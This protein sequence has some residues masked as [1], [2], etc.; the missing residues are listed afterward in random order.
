MKLINSNTVPFRDQV[1]T[2]EMTGEEL[3]RFWALSYHYETTHPT[4][5]RFHNQLT[6]MFPQ[7]NL[8]LK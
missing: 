5:S 4:D 6:K 1:F 7:T 3:I 2:I 8:A